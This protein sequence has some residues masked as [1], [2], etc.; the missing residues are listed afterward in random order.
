MN[1]SNCYTDGKIIPTERIQMHFLYPCSS[2]EFYS[3]ILVIVFLLS[4]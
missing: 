3:L 4:L 2:M 1:S